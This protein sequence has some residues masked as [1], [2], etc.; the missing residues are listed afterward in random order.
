MRL[1]DLSSE[2]LGISIHYQNI[3]LLTIIFINCAPQEVVTADERIDD[4]GAWVRNPSQ[5]IYYLTT[6]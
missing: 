2:Y 5:W 1:K 6:P 3:N 4:F